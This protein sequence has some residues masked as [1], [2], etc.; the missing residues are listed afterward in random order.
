MIAGNAKPSKCNP[1]KSRHQEGCGEV[2]KIAETPMLPFMIKVVGKKL[3]N[4]DGRGEAGLYLG[5]SLLVKG[6]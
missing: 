1:F 4:M 3:I 2:F 6:V 5:P